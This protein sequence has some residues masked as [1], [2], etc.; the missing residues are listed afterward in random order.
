MYQHQPKCHEGGDRVGGASEEFFGDEGHNHYD[1][2]L[3]TVSWLI[4]PR[5]GIHNDPA[6]GFSSLREAL[7]M[8]LSSCLCE[9][10][11]VL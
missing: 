5:L 9:S 10:L 11:F 1:R 4:S 3:C 2:N 6:L 8:L 7:C